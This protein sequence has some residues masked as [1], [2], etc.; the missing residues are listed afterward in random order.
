M[1]QAIATFL[2]FFRGPEVESLGVPRDS[3]VIELG[4]DDEE[5]SSRS[6]VDLTLQDPAWADPPIFGMDMRA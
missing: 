2:L 3:S 6:V 1:C 4:L 5:P